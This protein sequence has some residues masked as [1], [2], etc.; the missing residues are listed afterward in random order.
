MV[1]LSESMPFSI[2]SKSFRLEET[3]AVL[4]M[5]QLYFGSRDSFT[6]YRKAI[7]DC[8]Y[9]SAAQIICLTAGS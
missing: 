7:S 2:V 1:E 8:A 5:D 9:F 4:S 3:V 6:K